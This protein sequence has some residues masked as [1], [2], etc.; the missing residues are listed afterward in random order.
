[1]KGNL[2]A[3]CIPG[4]ISRRLLAHL[5]SAK[6]HISTCRG[7]KLVSCL[8]PSS[9]DRLGGSFRALSANW[10]RS[11]VTGATSDSTAISF[12]FCP[13]AR[14]GS[15]VLFINLGL[16]LGLLMTRHL[17]LVLLLTTDHLLVWKFP[18]RPESGH[19]VK[20]RSPIRPVKGV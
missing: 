1:V 7:L 15:G 4:C 19:L 20:P 13:A 9:L 14:R 8:H 17:S 11:F 12:G 5:Q 10:S 18:R 16:R 2:G 6:Q 3:Y